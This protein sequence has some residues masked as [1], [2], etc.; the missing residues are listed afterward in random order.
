MVSSTVKDALFRYRTVFL[1]Q[2]HLCALN[3]FIERTLAIRFISKYEKAPISI[4]FS[5]LL[6]WWSMTIFMVYGPSI[7]IVE[8]ISFVANVSTI[9]LMRRWLHNQRATSVNATTLTTRYQ[10]SENIRTLIMCR[11]W[12]Y[13]YTVIGLIEKILLL[14]AFICFLL[15]MK[16]PWRTSSNLYDLVNSFYMMF[17]TMFLVY[18]DSAL[19]EKLI[20]L[21]GRRFAAELVCSNKNNRVVNQDDFESY[22]QRLAASWETSKK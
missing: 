5:I 20:K 13:F 6:F 9:V 17:Y 22:F 2:V 12:V 3:V 10:I 4:G 15:G 1:L 14:I 8:S 7:V 11:Y 16:K 19:Q 21:I 18:G